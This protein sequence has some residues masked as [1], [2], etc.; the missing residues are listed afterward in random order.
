MKPAA[1]WESDDAAVVAAEFS[2]PRGPGRAT[3]VG[4]PGGAAAAKLAAGR[5]TAAERDRS[6]KAAGLRSA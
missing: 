4:R 6:G 5:G 3:P 1:K 2:P